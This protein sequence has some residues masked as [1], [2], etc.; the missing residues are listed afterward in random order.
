MLSNLTTK[1]GTHTMKYIL[2]LLLTT[3]IF[4]GE[5]DDYDYAGLLSY[6]KYI[7]M[8]KHI[9]DTRDLKY[10]FVED[11][12]IKL[13]HNLPKEFPYVFLLVRS[14]SANIYLEYI[15]FSKETYKETAHLARLTGKRDASTHMKYRPVGFYKN[16]KGDWVLDRYTTEGTPLAKCNACQTYKIKQYKLVGDKLILESIRGVDE[17]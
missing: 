5:I 3:G 8:M 12:E 13:I 4:A 10:A 6:P 17:L 7:S 2:I 1:K 16:K 11:T 9:S 14:S 15:L